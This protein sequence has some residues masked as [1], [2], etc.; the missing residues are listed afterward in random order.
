VGAGGG[1]WDLTVDQEGKKTQ[2]KSTDN[3]K[4]VSDGLEN[5]TAEAIK[6]FVDIILHKLDLK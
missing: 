5:Y 1:T 3:A 2:K 6:K 4:S